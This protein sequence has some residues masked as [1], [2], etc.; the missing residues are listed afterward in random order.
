MSHA[1]YEEEYLGNFPRSET[2]LDVDL[3]LP[4]P[5]RA[6]AHQGLYLSTDGDQLLG[7]AENGDPRAV[8]ANASAHIRPHSVPAS[9]HILLEQ[10]LLWQRLIMTQ[11][12]L[13]A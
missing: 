5:S 4:L 6:A 1:V 2:F 7:R 12:R 8:H 3:P 9:L 10:H 13:A 11:C